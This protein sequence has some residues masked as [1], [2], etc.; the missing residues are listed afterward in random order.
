MKLRPVNSHIELD[1]KCP[2]C[3]GI[4]TTSHTEVV[5]IGRAMCFMCNEILEFEPF[6]VIARFSD[7]KPSKKKQ[8]TKPNPEDYQSTRDLVGVLMS[9]GHGK[10][11]AHKIVNGGID[12]GWDLS[13]PA[14]F[15]QRAMEH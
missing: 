15:I 7:G 6:T 11:E 9:M 5:K 8:F 3:G 1:Y 10:G 14:D 4:I 2:K 12:A 13:D